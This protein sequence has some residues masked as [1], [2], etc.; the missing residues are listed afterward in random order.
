MWH[1]PVQC[2]FSMDRKNGV[3]DAT[4][5]LTILQFVASNHACEQWKPSPLSVPSCPTRRSANHHLGQLDCFVARVLQSQDR[6]GDEVSRCLS[7]WRSRLG[8]CSQRGAKT[9]LGITNPSTKFSDPKSALWTTTREIDVRL[10]RNPPRSKTSL[11]LRLHQASRPK[12]NSLFTKPIR[13]TSKPK[14]SFCV[15]EARSP[16][17]EKHLDEPDGHLALDKTLYP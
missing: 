14:R 6:E 16:R 9:S 7:H 17:R 10:C 11:R 12:P 15:Q 5:P 1:Q 2:K 13:D 8:T 3:Q 4:V